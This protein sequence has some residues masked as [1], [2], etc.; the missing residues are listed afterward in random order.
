MRAE[1]YVAAA[2]NVLVLQTIKYPGKSLYDKYGRILGKIWIPV[3]GVMMDLSERLLAEAHAVPYL[4]GTKPPWAPIRPLGMSD[5]FP[6][7][8]AAQI[9]KS[10]TT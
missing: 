1:N 9:L 3:G 7:A 4:G 6:E 2:D 10:W 5:P 8:V